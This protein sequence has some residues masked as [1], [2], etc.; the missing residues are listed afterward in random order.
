M[1]CHALLN[2]RARI[3]GSLRALLANPQLLDALAAAISRLFAEP[4]AISAVKVS[5]QRWDGIY[6]NYLRT[7]QIQQ[8]WPTSQVDTREGI[9]ISACR[10]CVRLE[11]DGTCH[12][13]GGHDTSHY[14]TAAEAAALLPRAQALV[15]QFTVLAVQTLIAQR[16]RTL[17]KVEAVTA[18]P[19]G[20]TTLTLNVNL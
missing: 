11:P 4:V 3:A 14:Y 1:P 8:P 6:L 20:V 2:Q 18:D 15:Q 16:L 13:R 17:G 7:R 5:P 9:D 10:G 12:I 19:Q